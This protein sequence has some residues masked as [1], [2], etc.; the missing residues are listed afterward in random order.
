M[1]NKFKKLL[2]LVTVVM[3]VLATFILPA[4]AADGETER[5]YIDFLESYYTTGLVEKGFNKASFD[6]TT[7]DLFLQ[8]DLSL[9]DHPYFFIGNSTGILVDSM[10]YGFDVV[11]DMADHMP[12]SNF[13]LCV[14]G[15]TTKLFEFI[16]CKLYVGGR[17]LSAYDIANTGSLHLSA[18]VDIVNSKLYYRFNKNVFFSCDLNWSSTTETTNRYVYFQTTKTQSNNFN[19]VR[20]KE[21]IMYEF[22]TLV[23]FPGDGY[24]DAYTQLFSDLIYYDYYT[25][26]FENGF[27]SGQ[28][29]GYALGDA[30]G[31]DRGYG[32]GQTDGYNSGYNQGQ[33]DGYTSGYQAGKNDGYNNGVGVKDEYWYDKG[34]ADGRIEG[35][36]EYYNELYEKGLEA[37]DENNGSMIQGFLSGMWNG[38]QNF[39]Q[40]LLDGITFS[41]LSLRSIVTTLF[42]ILFAAFIIRMLKG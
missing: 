37:I 25:S 21:M 9:V 13:I 11:L 20:I 28:D 6:H 38:V 22:P 27:V 12:N 19:S 2:C 10:C 4:S 26:G 33:T 1:K 7:G 36:N 15:K 8:P 35:K 18:Y 41:G 39:V 34:V 29:Y 3:I 31:Y 23:G 16:D 17:T 24:Y 40:E 14:N 30:A 42:A 5:L 32:K